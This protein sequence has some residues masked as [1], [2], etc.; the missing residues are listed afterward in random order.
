MRAQ[1][2]KCEVNCANST[3]PKFQSNSS[4]SY[5][6]FF[7]TTKIAYTL[8]SF[9]MRI[10]LW[11][12]IN[13]LLHITYLVSPAIHWLAFLLFFYIFVVR[14]YTRIYVIS[15]FYILYCILRILTHQLRIHLYA[16]L[17]P[18]QYAF[19]EVCI[20]KVSGIFATGEEIPRS[21]NELRFKKKR[22]FY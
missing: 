2:P 18:S 14:F 15:S 19:V 9:H 17:L 4:T 1:R 11:W 22:S 20:A 21:G 7:W 13:S 3:H 10:N 8:S 6:V 5:I 12:L 16:I